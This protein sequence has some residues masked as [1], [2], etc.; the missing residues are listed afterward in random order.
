MYTHEN[1]NSMPNMCTLFS[2]SLKNSQNATAVKKGVREYRLIMREKF[3]WAA[4]E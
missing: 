4:V 2:F 3:T 1:M